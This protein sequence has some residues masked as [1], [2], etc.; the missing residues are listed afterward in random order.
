[1]L[2]TSSDKGTCRFL[3]CNWP[4]LLPGSAFEI[5][6]KGVMAGFFLLLRVHNCGFWRAE[7]W[8]SEG[9]HLEFFEAQMTGNARGFDSIPFF[10]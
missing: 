5:S 4:C 9:L 2:L 10:W 6:L 3:V 8:G 1:M 7:S